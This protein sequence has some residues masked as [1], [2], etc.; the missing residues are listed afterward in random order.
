MLLSLVGVTFVLPNVLG[1]EGM[2]T[3]VCGMSGNEII[4]NYLIYDN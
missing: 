3:W 4:W 2:V 1:K